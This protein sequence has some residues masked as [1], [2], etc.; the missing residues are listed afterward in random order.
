[1]NLEK[2]KEPSFMAAGASCVLLLG[3]LLRGDSSSED[4]ADLKGQI[5][6]LESKWDDLSLAIVGAETDT[7]D[8]TTNQ[9]LRMAD[10]NEAVELTDGY[11]TEHDFASAFDM[12]LVASRISPSEPRLFDLVV[13]FVDEAKDSGEEAMVF[14]EDL[15]ARG[16]S[17]V[18]FQSPKDVQQCRQ[19]LME[20]RDEFWSPAPEVVSHSPFHSVQVLLSV[21]ENSS[22]PLAVRS[23][24]AEQARTTLNGT[25][26]DSFSSSDGNSEELATGKFTE[27]ESRVELAEAK[28]VEELFLEAKS[29]GDNWLEVA[30][31]LG[32]KSNDIPPDKVPGHSKQLAK[33]VTQGI[34]LL[35]EIMPYSKSE[36]PGAVAFS[37][38]IEKRIKALQRQKDWL[39]NQQVLRLIRE[40]ESEE[41]WTSED[42]IRQL[43][44]V[45]EEL[46]SPYVLGRHQELWSTI[47]EDLENEEKKVWAV[48]LRILR[49]DE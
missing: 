35:Q 19:R 24:A 20:M 37:R 28:C 6:N 29:K 26:L 46:L 4:I 11:L 16:E 5:A 10:F 32:E 38:T 33:A 47:F 25:L 41:S 14:A 15:L 9:A 21:S 13:R 34:N 22:I 31:S 40:V 7:A 12:V 1:M 43:A 48:K 18:H 17:L 42:K 30:A 36:V 39:Y 23:M 3:L 44:E 8:G 49:G 45:S 27:L 2:L